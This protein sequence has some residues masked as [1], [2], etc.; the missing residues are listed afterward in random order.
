MVANTLMRDPVKAWRA[1]T[2]TDAYGSAKR[3]W[4]AK[5]L[6]AQGM[7][8]V[9]PVYSFESVVDRQTTTEQLRLIATDPAFDVVEPYDRIEWRGR[10]LEVDSAVQV[11]AMQ[12]R[13]H[14][15]EVNLRYV[16]G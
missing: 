10:L 14:H 1:P 5:A 8:S 16:E 4:S 3:D 7:A 2:V 9:Q 11:Y 13:R 12:G 15:I 6:V